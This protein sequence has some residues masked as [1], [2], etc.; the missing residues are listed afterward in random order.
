MFLTCFGACLLLLLERLD[1]MTFASFGKRDRLVV[2]H[3]TTTKNNKHGEHQQKA[4]TRRTRIQTERMCR[5]AADVC[6]T[7]LAR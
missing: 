5:M 3:E 1:F 7:F 4:G 6:W 2:Q